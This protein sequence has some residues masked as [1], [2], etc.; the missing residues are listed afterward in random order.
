MNVVRRLFVLFPGQGEVS[1][2]SRV[3][4]TFDVRCSSLPQAYLVVS[5]CRVQLRV[6]NSTSTA[7]PQYSDVL[8]L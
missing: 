7:K 6:T 5:K 8:L 2:G 3:F 1:A 4:E